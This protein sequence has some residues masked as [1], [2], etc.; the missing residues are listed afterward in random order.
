M[1][2]SYFL[3]T[4]IRC[5]HSGT[6]EWDICQLKCH[7]VIQNPGAHSAAVAVEYNAQVLQQI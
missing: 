2:N 1:L 6:S 4:P 5:G 3:E 7:K